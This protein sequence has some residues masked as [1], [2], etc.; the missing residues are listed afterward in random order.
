MT[1]EEVWQPTATIERLR[2][3]ADLI[4]SLR[5]YFWQQGF[6]EVET[7][8][9][10]RDTVVDRHLDPPLVS[11]ESLGLGTRLAGDWYLQTSPE[12]GMKRLLAAGATKIFQ[13]GKA[14]R[15]AEFG[16]LHNPEFTLLEWYD[17]A[18]DYQTGMRFLEQ[19]ACDFFRVPSC[20]RLSHAEAWARSLESVAGISSVRALELWDGELAGLRAL[21]IE[22]CGLTAGQAG[23][24]DHDGLLST[25]WAE[26]VEPRLGLDSPVII[27]D[28][29]AI[30]AALAKTREQNGKQVAERFELYYRGVELANGYHELVDAE[31]LR[32]RAMINN[33]ARLADGKKQLPESSR[34]AEAMRPGIQMGAGVAAG[35]DRWVMLKL[36]CKSIR[37]V[38]AFPVERA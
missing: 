13:L 31:V 20:V 23:E 33:R 35:V 5:E 29:P 21:V 10:S 17:V 27:F 12:F 4:R 28:W 9:L 38:M 19:L 14:F 16:E 34:L 25:I 24:L 3:R 32:Q 6:W 2:M 30:Q 22:Q 8:L 7:P 1:T 15:A 11:A 37:E 36:G 18:A 26:M